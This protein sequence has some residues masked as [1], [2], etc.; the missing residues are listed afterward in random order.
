MLWFRY[1]SDH[2]T[3]LFRGADNGEAETSAPTCNKKTSCDTARVPRMCDFSCATLSVDFLLSSTCSLVESN[4]SWK[5]VCS[6]AVRTCVATIDDRCSAAICRLYNAQALINVRQLQWLEK[7]MLSTV[8]DQHYAS[9]VR[10]KSR[11]SC[12]QPD[13]RAFDALRAL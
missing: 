6:V 9:K 4:V 13:R 12:D 11:Q 8:R 10:Y 7:K 2:H 1:K 5:N 3:P